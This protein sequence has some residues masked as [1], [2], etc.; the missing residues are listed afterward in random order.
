MAQT[1]D[2]KEIYLLPGDYF[3]GGAGRR[4]RTLLGSCVSITLWHPQRRIGA[5]SH[6]LLSSRNPDKSAGL[7][8]RY[9][10]EALQ[11][12]LADL[13]AMGVDPVECQA[14][15]F[16][17]GQMFPGSAHSVGRQNGEVALRL[18][19]ELGIPVVSESL[20]G[21]GHRCIIFDVSSGNVWS[22]QVPPG[23]AADPAAIRQ[24]ERRAGLHATLAQSARQQAAAALAQAA[25]GARTLRE[26]AGGDG[27]A[28]NPA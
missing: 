27:H 1:T 18:L 21:V 9:G 20:Y 19:R 25:L 4:I 3:V 7:N 28:L 26:A 24:S 12:M 13:R 16:G 8:S 17:G 10:E 23:E 5:M 6:F 15:I 14:K 11:L 2:I 22:R